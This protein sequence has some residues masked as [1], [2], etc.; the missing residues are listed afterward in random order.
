MGLKPVVFVL[1]SNKNCKG[2]NLIFN[3]KRFFDLSRLDGFFC[4]E[5]FT[6]VKRFLNSERFIVIILFGNYSIEIPFSSNK[7]INFMQN[8]IDSVAKRLNPN[9]E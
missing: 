1:R 7:K 2:I 4:Q 5:I 6:R 3:I 8:Q 9:Y